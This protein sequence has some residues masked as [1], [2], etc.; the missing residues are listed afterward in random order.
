MIIYVQN[1]IIKYDYIHTYLHKY[2][3]QDN[4]WA[5]ESN[6]VK[7]KF[8]SF[9][10]RAQILNSSWTHKFISSAYWT[11]NE[12][13]WKYS[14]QVILTHFLPYLVFIYIFSIIN[15]YYFH[16][17]INTKKRKLILQNYP[18]I[19]NTTVFIFLLTALINII[20]TRIKFKKL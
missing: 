13:S 12:L 14:S 16:K 5:I 15:F 3:Y 10:K 17:Y 2:T 4:S 11:I 8:S 18:Y 6:I 20:N 7:L 9:N 1:I 19:R